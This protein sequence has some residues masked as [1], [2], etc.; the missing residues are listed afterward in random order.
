MK[1]KLTRDYKC[2]PQG[3]TTECYRKGDEVEGEAAELAIADGAAKKPA[4]R[5][6]KP[7]VAKTPTPKHEG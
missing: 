1:V 3:H 6:P 7:A 2:A 4:K 5:N